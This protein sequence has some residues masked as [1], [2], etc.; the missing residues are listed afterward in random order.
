MKTTESGFAGYRS[1]KSHRGLYW[2]LGFAATAGLAFGL[3]SRWVKVD[4]DISFNRKSEPVNLVD[5]TLISEPTA[6]EKQLIGTAFVEA[7]GPPAGLPSDLTLAASE[8]PTSTLPEPQ[9]LLTTSHFTEQAAPAHAAWTSGQSF[10]LPQP[11]GN[12]QSDVVF[13]A[14]PLPHQ[15]VQGFNLNVLQGVG[16]NS[17]AGLTGMAVTQVEPGFTNPHFNTGSIQVSPQGCLVGQCQPQ[18]YIF[19]Q[20]AGNDGFERIGV[21]F[22]IPVNFQPASKLAGSFPTNIHRRTIGPDGF[23]RIG[24]DFENSSPSLKDQVKLIKTFINPLGNQ[25][26]WLTIE[27]V[28]KEDVAKIKK[29]TGEQSMVRFL[30]QKTR[31]DGTVM[32][33]LEV[34]HLD[35]Q[36]FLTLF[37]HRQ[38]TDGK[39]RVGFDT[40]RIGCDFDLLIKNPENGNRPRAQLDAAHGIFDGLIQQAGFFLSDPAKGDAKQSAGG[41][42]GSAKIGPSTPGS[43]QSSGTLG[44]QEPDPLV[45]S[46]TTEIEEGYIKLPEELVGWVMEAKLFVAPGPDGCLR[47]STLD[48]LEQMFLEEAN[49]A[50]RASHASQMHGAYAANPTLPESS[51]DRRDR[52][53][54]RKFYGLMTACQPEEDEDGN[55]WIPLGSQ[56]AKQAGLRNEVVIVGLR[57]HVEIW[58]QQSWESEI[59]EPKAPPAPKALELQKIDMRK[60]SEPNGK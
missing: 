57:T 19:R 26:D 15:P 40:D 12:F 51:Q 4:L 1:T 22:D 35:R 58:S 25:M 20:I 5:P 28:D 43:N 7:F 56:L 30:G 3:A 17:N 42:G 6:A 34:P 24:V 11:A 29:F 55:L 44:A 31:P 37:V 2:G 50:L 45:G 36:D 13:F 8:L 23:E 52:R 10:P 38:G 33:Y 47:M 16:C 41:M 14:Q 21:D 46:F 32:T 9:P 53:T 49:D 60:K 39:I 18:P 59:S 48:G 54:M 27:N